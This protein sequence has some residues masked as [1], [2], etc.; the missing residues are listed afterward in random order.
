[1]D[2]EKLKNQIYSV[3]QIISNRANLPQDFGV[4]HKL[5]TAQIH[6]ISVIG[7][8]PGCSPL[9]LSQKLNITKGAVSQTLSKLEKMELIEKRKGGQYPNRIQI[10]LTSSGE[11]VLEEHQSHHAR[12]LE[13]LYAMME[14]TSKE[15]EQAIEKFLETLIEALC[16]KGKEDEL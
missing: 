8:K 4:G 15:E 2:R 12:K 3:I 6:I 11:Q 14:S 5:Y 10:Y 1:M 13:K 7:E 9:E 16:Q